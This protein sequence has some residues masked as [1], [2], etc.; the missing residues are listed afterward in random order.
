MSK[1]VPAP[2]HA[3]SSAASVH[4]L[5]T[6]VLHLTPEQYHTVH[7][8]PTHP[9]WGG[10]VL[11]NHKPSPPEHFRFT[12]WSLLSSRKGKNIAAAVHRVLKY[13]NLSYWHFWHRS[14]SWVTGID[15]QLQMR[16]KTAGVDAELLNPQ[17]P[18]ARTL[19]LFTVFYLLASSSP[20]LYLLVIL[21]SMN[22]YNLL[23]T[24]N[25]ASAS[26]ILDYFLLIP[27]CMFHKSFK[28]V[29]WCFTVQ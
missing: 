10:K 19:L 1:H 28:G 26:F 29:F 21:I 2:E 4:S 12:L 18:E 14:R 9:T 22:L 25:T 11:T 6:C 16:K 27:T 5:V 13:R 20:G 15:Q 23:K 24:Q 17:L 8:S 7:S 3:S